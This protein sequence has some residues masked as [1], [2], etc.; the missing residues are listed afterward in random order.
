MVITA[1]KSFIDV[2]HL[3]TP[4]LK[5]RFAKTTPVSLID[6]YRGDEMIYGYFDKDQG[7]VLY[8]NRI[9][10]P[11]RGYETNKIKFV[12][13][14]LHESIHSIRGFK[15][16]RADDEEVKIARM[17]ACADFE[18]LYELDCQVATLQLIN[19]NIKV[20]CDH[21]FNLDEGRVHKALMREKCEILLKCDEI[22]CLRRKN[23]PSNQLLSK[24]LYIP[25]S[26]I[27]NIIYDFN[28]LPE[29]LYNSTMAST[30]IFGD[31][32]QYSGST[33]PDSV[34]IDTLPITNINMARGK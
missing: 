25:W 7:I 29:M 31:Y 23:L 18:L 22:Q 2:C 21:P 10:N 27:G 4:E 9:F 19:N 34:L 16:E 28:K 8:L 12:I 32:N 15:T 33:S 13:V 20:L 5:R 11:N 6:N 30:G 24:S 3:L 17:N 14:F 26:K 1:S